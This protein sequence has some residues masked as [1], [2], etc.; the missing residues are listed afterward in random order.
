MVSIVIFRLAD[1]CCQL[2]PASFFFFA[3]YLRE[4]IKKNI[5]KASENLE[6]LQGKRTRAINRKL[7]DVEALPTDQAAA[8]LP[9][10]NNESEF[11]D[12]DND[13]E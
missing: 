5:E 6:E 8:F 7:K 12:D 11:D 1:S 3:L 4:K 13:D 9:E 10:M 2:T